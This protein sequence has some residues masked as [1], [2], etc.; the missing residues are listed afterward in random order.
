MSSSLQI[1]LAKKYHVDDLPGAALTGT[2]L[3]GI[4][5]KIEAGD[6]LSALALSFLETRGFTALKALSSCQIDLEAYRNQAAQERAERMKLAEETAVLEEAERSRQTET[7][8]A[9]IKAHFD[10]MKNDPVLRRRREA[11]E[12]RARFYIGFVEPEH[13]PRV[14]SLLRQVSNR[15]R[16]RPEDVAWLST[17][18]D[19]CWTSKLQKA[20]HELEAEALSKAWE[21]NRDPWDAVNASGHWRKAGNPDMALLITEAALL[22]TGLKPKLR[23]AL[24]TTRG[25]AMRDLCRLGEA[26]TMGMEAHELSPADFRPCTLLGAVHIELGELDSGHKW[27]QRAEALGAERHSID[28][29]LRALLV[30]LAPNESQ[31]FRDFLLKQDP[32][33]FSWVR[34]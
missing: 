30:G 25:G 19:Y 22:K 4:L 34:G 13:F 21:D 10:A 32:M 18:A 14:M 7:Q 8:R 28:Q 1:Q 15:Q 31:R 33:R 17:E 16:L 29:E 11:K 3:N 12:L 27:Y 2:R 23:S 9:A 20:W 6:A 24:A 5:N 26:K